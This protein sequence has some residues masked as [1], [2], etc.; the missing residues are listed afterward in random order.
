MSP[1]ILRPTLESIAQ[2][3]NSRERSQGKNCACE[4]SGP[5]SKP[6]PG[7]HKTRTEPL[8]QG[9][10]FTRTIKVQISVG[11]CPYIFEDTR[12]YGESIFWSDIGKVGGGM[13]RI[14][15]IKQACRDASARTYLAVRESGTW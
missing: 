10:V 1:N 3:T 9:D 5:D 2:G 13:P 14:K 11:Y 6:R 7:E 8:G 15:F 12:Q 4:L